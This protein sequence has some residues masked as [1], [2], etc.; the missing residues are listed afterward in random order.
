M[1]AQRGRHPHRRADK[2][3][4]EKLHSFGAGHVKFGY[5]VR[6]SL[7]YDNANFH[8]HRTSMLAMASSRVRAVRQ[9]VWILDTPYIF[10]PSKKKS[11]GDGTLKNSPLAKNPAENSAGI[12]QCGGFL[13]RSSFSTCAGIVLGRH[14][15]HSID[16]LRSAAVHRFAR[17]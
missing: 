2:C 15:T 10:P 3:L 7:L 9:E 14:R 12:C 17:V 11:P 1:H 16:R 6:E 5:V 13:L 4:L 8:V